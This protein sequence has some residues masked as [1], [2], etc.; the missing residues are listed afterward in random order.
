MGES[1]LIATPVHV[2]KERL[3]RSEAQGDEPFWNAVYSKAFYN[4]VN[5]MTCTGDTQSQRQGIDRILHLAGGQTLYIDEKKR[6]K[7]YPDILLEYI[8]VDTTGA[9]GWIEKDLNIDYLAYAFMPSKRCY[10][11]PWLQLR[12]AWIKF[13]PKWKAKYPKV[14]AQNPGYK[15]ISVA[16]PIEVLQTAI[17]VA[18]IID[19]STELENT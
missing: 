4:L 1:I 18:A 16:V 6:D 15:T 8:S 17:S 2:F 13:G 19:V 3:A 14:E 5:H 11:L 9:P 7:D 10:L 12:R